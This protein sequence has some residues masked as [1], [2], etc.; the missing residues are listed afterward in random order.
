MSGSGSPFVG[1]L[2]L[3]LQ[4]IRS[5]LAALHRLSQC[6]AVKDEDGSYAGT[7]DYTAVRQSVPT[8]V[9][10]TEDEASI[11]AARALMTQHAE[12]LNRLIH[13]GLRRA[14]MSI[15]DADQRSR[16]EKVLLYFNVLY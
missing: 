10:Y 11:A 7:I 8:V 3:I 2:S 13:S 15:A 6:V 12:A 9:L 16:A 14:P 4:E 5:L 1:V